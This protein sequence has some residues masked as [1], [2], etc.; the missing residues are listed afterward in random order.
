MR[1]DVS[2][3]S[4]VKLLFVSKPKYRKR[5]YNGDGGHGLQFANVFLDF[6]VVL[7]SA[8]TFFHYAVH[9]IIDI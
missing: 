1:L 8:K 2:H 3:S 9:Y 5:T 6:P 4:T 7:F